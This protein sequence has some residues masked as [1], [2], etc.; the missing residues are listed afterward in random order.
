MERLLTD[1]FKEHRTITRSQYQYLTGVS[2]TSACQ[3]L[4]HLY[5]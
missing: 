4:K 5:E 3:Q 1:Y 2:R